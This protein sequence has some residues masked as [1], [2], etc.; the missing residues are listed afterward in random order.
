V[1]LRQQSPRTPHRAPGLR[2][3]ALGAA[4]SLGLPIGAGGES[5]APKPEPPRISLSALSLAEDPL[6]PSQRSRPRPPAW[7]GE[8]M[9]YKKGAG[10]EYRRELRVG[11][12]PLELGVAGPVV[13]KKK[14]VGLMF[15][16]RF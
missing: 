8:N 4:L 14:R 13:R 15:E 11:D 6:E 3:A 12:A 7:M 10:F 2:L 1:K 16:V 5:A 9:H